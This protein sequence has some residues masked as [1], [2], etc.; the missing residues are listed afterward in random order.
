MGAL[1]A[2]AGGSS[3]ADWDPVIY[4]VGGYL[5]IVA[6]LL[7]FGRAS[8]HPSALGRFVLRAP[9]ALQHVTG[10]PGW[11]AATVGTALYGLLIAGQGFYSDVAWHIALG[12]D[13]ELFT[14]PHTGIFIG[15]VMIF[16]AALLG[17]AFASLAKIET[18]IRAGAL[19]I[20]WS[21][22]PLALLGGA[23]VLG[24]P[25]DEGWHAQYGID[26]TMWSPTHMLMILGASFTGVAGWLVLADARVSPRTT[27]WATGAHV[28]A[29]WLTLQ[30]LAASQGEFAFG[31]PQFQQ[32]FHPILVC[33]AAGFAIVAIRLVLGPFYALAIT[34]VT[35]LLEAGNLLNFGGDDGPVDT[36]HGGVYV[37]SAL[38]VELVARV[39]G[40]ERRLRFAL[41]S[42][43]AVGTVGL[44]SEWA[45][46]TRAYQPW[47]TALL[48]E[49][50]IF[51]AAAAVAAA[52]LGAAFGSA[53]G[54]E[55]AH[56]LPRWSLVAATVVLLAVVALP[57]PRQTGDVSAEMTLERATAAPGTAYVNLTLTPADAADDAKWFQAVNW[58]GGGLVLADMEEVGPGRFRSEA[59]VAIS[60]KGKTLVRLHRGDELMAFPVRLPADPEIGEPEIPAI[61]RSGAFAGE[62]AFLMREAE[63]GDAWYAA[64]IYV[65]LAGVAV[66]W[67]AAFAVASQRVRR[68]DRPARVRAGTEQEYAAVR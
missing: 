35:A 9:N 48:P 31:V 15:L 25:L 47:E 67:M 18:P 7:V 59:P 37:V 41:A 33:L 58:Q 45:W 32:V 22:V 34:G 57:M 43:L 36:R 52:V 61:D 3:L 2:Q 53:V 66:A 24:F 5:A 13:D 10:I 12:R 68:T 38:A 54:R 11:A 56:R 40:T 1:L 65:L 23:A 6:A 42:G 17:I 39:L 50:L 51:G 26:V 8:D 19:R 20:P 63:T 60:G 62:K 30:G 64:L 27:R 55:P 29:G 21:T 49:A 4:L 16:G 14:A 28:L 44:A 46:N